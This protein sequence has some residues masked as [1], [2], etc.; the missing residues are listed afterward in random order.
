MA[1]FLKNEGSLRN[2]GDSVVLADLG[3]TATVQAGVLVHDRHHLFY[4]A[5]G[6]KAR[7][8]EQG[9]V[10]CLNVGVKKR[11]PARAVTRCQS[12]AGG[13][14]RLAGAPLTA[15]DSDTHLQRP[16]FSRELR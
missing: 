1:Q 5:G 6:G 15:G 3:A 13:D 8:N 14:E 2:G 4:D 9:R 7:L 16:F 11:G 10:R 12:E